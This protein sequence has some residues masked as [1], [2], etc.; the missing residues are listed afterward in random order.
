MTAIGRHYESARAIE[1]QKRK[2]ERAAERSFIELHAEHVGF[3]T[4][5]EATHYCATC[6]TKF[7]RLMP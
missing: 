4:I 5:G 6:K 1:I 2:R 7:T 3:S